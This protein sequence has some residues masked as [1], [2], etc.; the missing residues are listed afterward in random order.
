MDNRRFYNIFP[1]IMELFRSII[2]KR[3][4][5]TGGKASVYGSW[6]ELTQKQKGQ[7][8]KESSVQE[9]EI[10]ELLGQVTAHLDEIQK[11]KS[12]SASILRETSNKG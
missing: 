6:L 4:I 1:K 10:R 5:I 12:S 7:L 9:S 3:N 2:A 8:E 11:Q